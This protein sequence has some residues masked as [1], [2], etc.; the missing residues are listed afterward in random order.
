MSDERWQRIQCLFEAAIERDPAER[1]SFL[2]QACAGDAE[3]RAAVDDLLVHDAEAERAKFL[4]AP[5][6]PTIA[7][8]RHGSSRERRAPA[9]YE[10][11]GELGRGGM[12]VVYKAIQS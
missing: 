5:C 1:T 8:E 10:I 12:A 11:V 3:L 7:G 9:G 4:R 2:A 6:G